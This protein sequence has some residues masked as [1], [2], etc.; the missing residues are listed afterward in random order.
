MLLV[1]CL[2]GFPLAAL[3]FYGLTIE[4][5]P[6]GFT[7]SL[8]AAASSMAVAFLLVESILS[9]RSIEIAPWGVAFHYPFHT[10]RGGW[11]DLRPSTR[12]PA[13]GEWYLFRSA[14]GKSG[15]KL[16]SH[17]LTIEQTRLLLLSPYC[18]EWSLPEYLIQIRDGH[19]AD[20]EK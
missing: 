7:G 18:P 13:H 16:R 2:V 14:S 11:D 15:R 10:E 20:D 4:G 9:V 12:P 19:P 3:A 8:V 6:G 1:I 5:F 17:R